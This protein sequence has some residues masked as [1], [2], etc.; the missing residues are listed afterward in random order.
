[1]NQVD[2]QWYKKIWTLGMQDQS[3]VEETVQ[4]VDFVI[5]ALE[6]NGN[7][8]VLDLGCGFGRHALELARRGYCVT[9]V[10]ITPAFIDE[11]HRQAGLA[12][13]KAEFICAD[14]RDIH[15][16]EAFDVVLN[17][18]DGA[19]GYLENDEENLKIFDRVA[20]A[21]R[22]GGKHLMGVNSAEYAEKH[23]PCRHWETGSRSLALADFAWDPAS[24][25]MIYTSY[26]LPYQ[27]VLTPPEGTQ[28]AIRLYTLKELEE[29]LRD[30]RM[31]IQR[32]YGGYRTRL[33]DDLDHLDVVVC[34][35]KE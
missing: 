29:I 21:L 10:D 22:P 13:V 30:R 28:S 14:L 7:E 4:E 15:F 34:S 23:F 31:E 18:A 24:R 5:E 3:W 6:L 11:A 27:Q 35:Q 12:G 26:T 17:M 1:M 33:R 2:P 25:R 19:I 32:V 16:Q 20:A 9:G 8:R